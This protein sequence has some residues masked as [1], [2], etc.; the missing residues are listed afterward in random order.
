MEVCSSLSSGGAPSVNPAGNIAQLFTFIGPQAAVFICQSTTAF[1]TAEAEDNFRC[2]FQDWIKST[3]CNP[4]LLPPST[5]YK[6]LRK[7]K[8]D[9]IPWFWCH[10]FLRLRHTALA[11]LPNMPQS[12]TF[13]HSLD[14]MESSSES[15]AM[16]EAH[17]DEHGSLSS[18]ARKLF[19]LWERKT[20]IVTFPPY[21]S[22][23]PLLPFIFCPKVTFTRTH[24]DNLPCL[25]TR[26]CPLA[27][28]VLLTNLGGSGSFILQGSRQDKT[29]LCRV[30]L[31]ALHLPIC[32]NCHNISHH[33]YYCI[34]SLLEMSDQG[35]ISQTA[36]AA[37]SK[38][39]LTFSMV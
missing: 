34:Y 22:M 3:S 25:N 10:A 32:R 2:R 36:I 1:A 13:L 9:R 31:S 30:S 14:G 7:K 35:L 16:E 23:F 27:T 39:V 26:I 20:P 8:R 17:G 24:S 38:A 6:V 18:S 29:T 19:A 28:W 11:P 33:S 15:S 4:H 5:E 37:G 21:C 12:F